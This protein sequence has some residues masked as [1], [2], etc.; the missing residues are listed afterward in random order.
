MM[1]TTLPETTTQSTAI[2]PGRLAQNR[3]GQA[4]IQAEPDLAAHYS[5]AELD[6]HVKALAGKLLAAARNREGDD[7]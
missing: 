1:S 2:A 4:L 7:E 5:A 6:Q 3:L